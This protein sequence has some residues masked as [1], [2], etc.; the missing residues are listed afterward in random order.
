MCTMCTYINVSFFFW[1]SVCCVSVTFLYIA[2]DIQG[3]AMVT[4]DSR[5]G[6][7]VGIV[8]EMSG[9]FSSMSKVKCIYIYMV[10]KFLRLNNIFAPV[11]LFRET[12]EKQ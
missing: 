6:F 12:D 2:L 9:I 5:L 8:V 10:H 1:S 3:I 4:K 7:D 11:N